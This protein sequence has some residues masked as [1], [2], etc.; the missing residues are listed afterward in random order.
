VL[1]VIL[2]ASIAL[3]I[4][5]WWLIDAWLAAIAEVPAVFLSFAFLDDARKQFKH[6]YNGPSGKRFSWRFAAWNLK[7]YDRHLD[8][9]S[10]YARHALPIDENRKRFPKVG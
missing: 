6:I 10:G 8:N 7:Y 9:S 1:G 2:L 3:A 4:A 5:R